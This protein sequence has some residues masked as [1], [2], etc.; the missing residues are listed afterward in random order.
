MQRI[1]PQFNQQAQP[2]QR[3]TPQF[4]QQAR[5]QQLP[6]QRIAPQFNQRA[7]PQNMAPRPGMA[8]VAG[9]KPGVANNAQRSPLAGKQTL[10]TPDPRYVPKR[11]EGQGKWGKDC[12]QGPRS[13]QLGRGPGN[14]LSNKFNNPAQPGQPKPEPR[15]TGKLAPKPP[16]TANS[17]KLP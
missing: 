3:L 13:S 12:P 8:G 14:C 11:L 7:M 4:N 10:K 9:S 1:T 6:Q 2:Q 15:P 16:N 17:L 5:P